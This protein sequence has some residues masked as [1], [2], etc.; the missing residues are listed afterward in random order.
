TL[1][2]DVEGAAR[3]EGEE[4]LQPLVDRPRHLDRIG[5]AVRFHAAGKVHR[6]APQVVDVLALADHAGHHRAAVD[7]DAQ[8]HR[9]AMLHRVLAGD[10][11]HADRHA[12]H[13]LGMIFDRVGQAAHRHVG[14][15]H[16]LDLLDADV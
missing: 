2:L 5:Q 12:H 4:V 8:A 1:A 7:A 14:V 13:T 15:A 10:V 9:H 3:L 11:D 6:V 16:G